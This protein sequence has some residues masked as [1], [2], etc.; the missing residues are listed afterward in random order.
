MHPQ[1]ITGTAQE[2][3]K[4]TGDRGTWSGKPTD[5][6][7][8]WSRC[9][10]TGASCADISGANSATYLLTTADVANTLRFKVQAR[11]ADGNTFSS[12][13]PTA[14]VIAAVVAPVAPAT[15]CPA[16][17]GAIQVADVASP[18]R[19]LIDQ[20]QSD[21]TVVNRSTTQ[22]SLRYHV[23]GCGG[24]SVQGVMVY[25]TIPG[26]QATDKDGWASLSFQ[27]TAG[28]PTGPH[29]QLIALFVRARKSG[30]DLLG[31]ISTRRLFSVPV[32]L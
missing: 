3:Q 13:A 31:G 19:L 5:F 28:S 18:A 1:T 6:N 29:Q 12:S 17:T 20:Q 24:R 16:G 21:P 7:Y 30:E 22:I 4:L 26:E 15:G 11:N 32:K 8:F 9:D 23:S 25:A 14:V 2:G 10:K 27:T